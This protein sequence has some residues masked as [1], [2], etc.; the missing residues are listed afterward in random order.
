LRAAARK[1]V[2]GVRLFEFADRRGASAFSVDNI[3][4][5]IRQSGRPRLRWF[6]GSAG[7]S[8]AASRGSG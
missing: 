6:A 8:N 2:T 1:V 7:G 5:L 4:A 3:E